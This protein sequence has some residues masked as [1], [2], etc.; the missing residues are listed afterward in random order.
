MSPFDSLTQI[1]IAEK[2][3]EALYSKVANVFQIILPE[4][5]KD[6][7]PEI[8]SRVTDSKSLFKRD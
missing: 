1:S 8:K 6:N 4:V 5:E 3:R 2:Q 7:Q